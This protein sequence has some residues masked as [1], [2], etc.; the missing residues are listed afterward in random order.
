MAGAFSSYA[1]KSLAVSAVLFLVA[2]LVA[3]AGAQEFGPHLA[4]FA[5]ASAI[6]VGINVARLKYC[7]GCDIRRVGEISVQAGWLVT[8]LSLVYITMAPAK[9][10]SMKTFNLAVTEALGLALLAI[11]AALLI[12]TKRETGVSLSV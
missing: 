7:S 12:K 6:L 2:G 1:V 3:A 10:Y 8:S 9:I 5:V 11:G 4:Y